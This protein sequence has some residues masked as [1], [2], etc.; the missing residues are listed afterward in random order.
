MLSIEYLLFCFVF[1]ILV[2]YTQQNLPPKTFLGDVM[3]NMVTAVNNTV[4]HI[5]KLLR[6]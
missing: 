3:Y 2:K 4:L 1:K 5:R 6:E